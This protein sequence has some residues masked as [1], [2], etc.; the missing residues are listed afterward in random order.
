MGVI[1]G[2][3][4]TSHMVN[5]NSICWYLPNLLSQWKLF[6]SDWRDQEIWM[7]FKSSK[8]RVAT[9]RTPFWMKVIFS[10]FS[11]YIYRV[12]QKNATFLF[13][14]NSKDGLVY[15]IA[16]LLCYLIFS[17][18]C[19]T[20]LSNPILAF[21]DFLKQGY[22]PSKFKYDFQGFLFLYQNWELIFNS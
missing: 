2:R 16:L 11:I 7:P 5:Q 13:F 15:L 20:I 18:Y 1:N 22:G 8:S 12:S 6:L 17:R 21:Y 4:L 14:N 10:L 3:R 19:H 9:W